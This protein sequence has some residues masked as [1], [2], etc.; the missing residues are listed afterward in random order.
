VRGAGGGAA[1]GP[2]KAHGAETWQQV[3]GLK[4]V[5]AAA[6][7]PTRIDAVARAVSGCQPSVAVHVMLW[8]PGAKLTAGGATGAP[9]SSTQATVGPSLAVKF[10]AMLA[11]APGAAVKALAGRLTRMVGWGTAGGG[12][13]GREHEEEGV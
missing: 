11:L 2:P 8:G 1:A 9:R 13:G 4:T 5:A 7:A 3:G 12:G 6:H 10:Q